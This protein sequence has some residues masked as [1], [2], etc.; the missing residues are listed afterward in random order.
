[1]AFFNPRNTLA[2]L[3]T[4]LIATF[5]CTTASAQS[6]D[7]AAEQQTALDEILVTARKREERLQ[8]I[9]TSAAALTADFLVN[10]NP[11]ED[12]RE[13][14]D[15]IP[16]ITVNDVNLYFLTEPSI[17]GGGA[18]RNRYSASATGLYRNGAYV[19]S[20][21]PGGKNFARMDYF[22]MERAEVLRGPQGALYGRNA[23]GGAI[24]LI[25]KKPREEFSAD[26][27]LRA[28]ELD[29]QAA[30]LIVNVPLGEQVSLRASHVMEDRDEGFYTDIN[31]DYVDT[32]DYD[33]TRIAFRYQPRLRPH[34][35]RIS[36]STCRQC[37][38][39]LHLGQTRP[40]R[41]TDDPDFPEP[42]RPDW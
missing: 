24:N 27:T 32:I 20:A 13:L 6:S 34:S 31:G 30:E 26:L 21:G 1:M 3:G 19:A 18:G 14:T 17:R 7:A 22:D 42:G 28:G 11:I 25:S 29:M 8:D 15:L 38:Y 10:L 33:H 4:A 23:L 9:P 37:G 2:V 35:N 36:L 39:C 40:E 16:G 12:I 5:I 41:H